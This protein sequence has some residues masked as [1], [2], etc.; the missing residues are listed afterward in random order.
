MS[1]GTAPHEQSP[2]RHGLRAR[3]P[4]RPAASRSQRAGSA[5][6]W[7]SSNASCASAV[8]LAARARRP[9]SVVPCATFGHGEVS[10]PCLA[11][12]AER[13]GRI[14][15]AIEVARA[16]EPRVVEQHANARQGHRRIH[17]WT[18]LRLGIGRVRDQRRGGI[19]AATTA[20]REH[21][22]EHGPARKGAAAHAPATAHAAQP[23]LWRAA[24][25]SSAASSSLASR[26]RRTPVVESSLVLLDHVE[27]RLLLRELRAHRSLAFTGR[28]ELIGG[29]VDRLREIGHLRA[30]GVL[31][32]LCAG[33]IGHAELPV[34]E[35]VGFVVSYG[36]RAS[37]GLHPFLL[38][39]TFGSV[40]RFTRPHGVTELRRSVL[41]LSVAM[42]AQ[43]ARA[44]TSDSAAFVND[45]V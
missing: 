20:E 44:G 10:G 43:G 14:L 1:S 30:R 7:A 39:P 2:R 23:C 13:S 25:T 40:G 31:P 12:R 5:G 28:R 29:P 26:A 38:R 34:C 3:E 36:R 24:K 18:G 45:S 35:T 33:E 6:A 11:Q 4:G 42:L 37:L 21:A 22:R 19:R 17:R 15:R 32:R 9:S 41:D 16:H 27:V 8:A